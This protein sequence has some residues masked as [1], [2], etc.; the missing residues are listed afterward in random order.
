M[1]GVPALRCASAKAGGEGSTNNLRHELGELRHHES[2]EDMIKRGAAKVKKLGKSGAC[3]L[4]RADFSP[5]F[6]CFIHL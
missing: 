3:S 6:R 5:V 2:N 1:S 4:D